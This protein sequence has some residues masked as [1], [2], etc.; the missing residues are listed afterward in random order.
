VL[1][2]GLLSAVQFAMNSGL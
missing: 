2:L 1:A